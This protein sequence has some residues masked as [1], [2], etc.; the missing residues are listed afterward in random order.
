M[1]Q[2]VVDF[3]SRAEVW[4]P[5]LAVAAALALY[6]VLR[7][8]A[9]GQSARGEPSEAE[10]SPRPGYR[11]RVAAAV[12]A[13]LLLV[14]LGAYVAMAR[15]LPWSL[16][17]FGAGFG[18][19]MAVSRANRRYRHVSPSLRRIVALADAALTGTLFAG[20]LI[21]GNVLAFRYGERPFDLTREGVFSLHSLTINQLH[22]LDKPAHFIAFYGRSERSGRQ[23]DRVI[24]L[25]ELYKAENPAKVSYEVV[26]PFSNPV[27]YEDLIRRAPGVGVSPGGGVLIEYGPKEAPERVVVRNTEL[28][29]APR[30]GQERPGSV[31][32]GEDV[33]TSALIRLRE[34]KRAK[35]AF[36]TGHG[37]PSIHETDPSKPGLGL[38]RTRLESV[39]A[40]VVV[41]NLQTGALPTD[42]ALAII[43]GIRSPF[44]AD[45]AERL[46]AY[47]ARGGRVLVLIDGLSRTGLEGW[48]ATFNVELGPELILDSRYNL[49]GRP[50]L[51]R[52]PIV[53][54]SRHPIVD[55]LLNQYPVVPAASPIT[56]IGQP[57]P[58][59]RASALK[60]NPS[61]AVTPILR[62]S[63]DSWAKTEADIR[64]GKFAR[65][66][67]K[68]PA[69]PL[70]VG[71]AA[72][73]A[74]TLGTR[75]G[76]ETPRLVV[77]SSAR[78][79]D[80]GFV[81]FIP[82]NLDL[83]VN[84][85]NWLRGRTDLQGIAPRTHTPLSLAADPS[86]RARLVVLPTVLAF[87]II[88]GL[89]VATYLARRS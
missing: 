86:L 88:I 19:V 30:S 48:L 56:L 21:V 34:A 71:V 37:E 1:S 63:P 10:G 42:T 25:L 31:F 54:D 77:F 51:P 41:H 79:A 15:S 6:W 50:E 55:P 26:N 27:V 74:P 49:R 9:P 60:P 61:I 75:A 40:Q 5:A 17:L 20:V 13:G 16:P 14:G 57:G 65:D 87:A 53:G 64:A 80:N 59:G 58:G 18:I 22:K 68:D 39:G 81:Y 8:A 2:G 32:R 69:G 11:D 82:D 78:M 3:L 67:Q 73:D 84:A 35:V 45:E 12:V 62:T 38:L 66:P 89:G 46:R 52:A 85:A 43:A 83:I 33:L 28:F 70:I 24:Q 44:Q 23:L 72:A 36:L 47:V 4:L 7:G 76:S 29:E